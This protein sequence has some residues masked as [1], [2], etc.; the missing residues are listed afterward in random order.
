[1]KGKTNNPNG[2]PKGARN[3][4]TNDLKGWINKIIERNTDT[5]ES[6]LRAL[7]PKD[8]L[9]LLEKMFQYIIP[10]MQSVSVEAQI[11]AEYEELRILLDNAP[12]VLIDELTER[13]KAIQSHE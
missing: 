12:E 4:V 7:E 10:R 13:I 9:Q 11:K 8:R 3:K 5:F 1:M 6:D 2:R